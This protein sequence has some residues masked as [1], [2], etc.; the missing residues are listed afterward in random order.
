M[1]RTLGR[2]TLKAMKRFALVLLL[3]TTHCAI[4]APDAAPTDDAGPIADAGPTPEWKPTASCE[5]VTATCGGE[6]AQAVRGHAAGLVDLEGARVEFAVRYLT[7]EGK[8]LD[9]PH[10]V[11]L[12][13]TVVAG[14]AFE[15]CVCVP[16]GANM[17]PQIAAV[18]YRPGTHGTVSADVARATFSQ[19][20]ATL[21]DEDVAYALGSVPSAAQKEAAIAAMSP[22]TAT[23]VVSDLSAVEGHQ[24]LGGLV[25]AERP[26]AAQL[27]F[28]GVEAGRLSLTWNMPGR[29]YSTER[30][31]FFVDRN[32]NGKCDADGSDAGA[33]IDFA[34]TIA[35][36]GALLEGAAL[37]PVCA[38]LLPGTPRE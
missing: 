37:A 29:A 33:F 22:R 12:G 6:P 17:Y 35:H 36:P 32:K 2:P 23:V 25:A 9:M 15:T 34:P 27:S 31:A 26:I 10:D 24:V 14:G 16:H 3:A 38:A 21:G 4:V 1:A 28:G 8:G 7:E 18:V 13:R 20:Y 11:A 19:R 5:E 30:V